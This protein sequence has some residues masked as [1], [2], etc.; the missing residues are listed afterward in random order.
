LRNVCRLDLVMSV[1]GFD[2]VD[3]LPELETWDTVQP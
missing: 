1:T 3:L 2:E